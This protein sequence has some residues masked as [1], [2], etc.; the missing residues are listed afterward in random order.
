MTAL[1]GE[2]I[3]SFLEFLI[4]VA[5]VYVAVDILGKMVKKWHH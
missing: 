2:L 5:V 3:I 1:R 4:L